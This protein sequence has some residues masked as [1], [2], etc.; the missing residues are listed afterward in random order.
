M[1]INL[2]SGRIVLNDTFDRYKKP[3]ILSASNQPSPLILKNILLLVKYIHPH[4]NKN[5]KFI[6]GTLVK[7]ET[8]FMI[9]GSKII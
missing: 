3:I 7:E 4:I 1:S 9:I 5:K 6:L 8:I 2:Y